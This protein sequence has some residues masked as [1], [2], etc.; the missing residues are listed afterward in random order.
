MSTELA[1]DISGIA[2]QVWHTISPTSPSL[3]RATFR[4]LL[5]QDIYQGIL[6]TSPDN[7]LFVLDSRSGYWRHDV[8]RDEYM[9]R[10]SVAI[11]EAGVLH[12]SHDL[13]EYKITQVGIGIFTKL[14]VKKDEKDDELPWVTLEA[15]VANEEFAPYL[16][17]IRDN[18]PKYKGGRNK[19][20]WSQATPKSEWV[21]YLN[22]VIREIAPVFNAAVVQVDKAEADDIM[23][24]LAKNK[25]DDNT[26]IIMAEDG[27]MDQLQS[28]P[29]VKRLRL[30]TKELI[31]VEDPEYA[32]RV[33]VLHGDSGDNV[34]SV[35]RRCPRKPTKKDPS[36]WIMKPTGIVAAHEILSSGSVVQRATEEGWLRDLE[37]NTKMI[38]LG[39]AP[40]ELQDAI[41]EECKTALRNRTRSGSI[42]SFGVP[43]D[44]LSMMRASATIKRMQ[45][46]SYGA[47]EEG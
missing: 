24:C 43:E 42:H 39:C 21:G 44:Q 4:T 27:D 30:S 5:F 33:K 22:E 9:S 10:V 3:E 6:E 38:Y 19:S 23:H 11:D 45:F 28:Y 7:V 31:E 47:A 36:A 14:E 25:G 13:T 8:Y 16:S 46:S 2:H 29:N 1:I 34:K 37:F 35:K 26:I 12:M 40:Q 41:Y 18:F 20:K 32:I 17:Q 15:A